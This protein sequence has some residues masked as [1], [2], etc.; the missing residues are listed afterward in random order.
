MPSLSSG[1]PTSLLAS[2][3]SLSAY[4]AALC[5]IHCALTPI[6][7]VFMP[8]LALS[9]AVERAVWAAAIVIGALVFLAGPTR[10]QLGELAI[11]AAG[12]TL[13]AASLA[14]KLEPLPETWTSAAGSLI[15]ATALWRSARVCRDDACEACDAA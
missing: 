3:S 7:I 12:A 4:A 8:A 14:G 9:E 1:R 13:W 6:L 11:F 15:L 5:G 2:G 10:K